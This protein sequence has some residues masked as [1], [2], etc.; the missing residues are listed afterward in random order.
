MTLLENGKKNMIVPNIV[1]SYMGR[2]YDRLYKNILYQ[3]I[4]NPNIQ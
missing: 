2:L 3:I 1:I 4:D